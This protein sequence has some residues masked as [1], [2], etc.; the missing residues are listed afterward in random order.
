MADENKAFEAIVKKQILLTGC[1]FSKKENRISHLA[2]SLNY[3]VSLFK[4]TGKRH[5]WSRAFEIG[6]LLVNHLLSKDYKSNC[7]NIIEDLNSLIQLYLITEND[8]FLIHL[9]VIKKFNE[10]LIY[11]EISKNEADLKKFNLLLLKLSFFDLTGNRTLLYQINQDISN[12]LRSCF[13]YKRN[14]KSTYRLFYDEKDRYKA[15]VLFKRS[16]I[17]TGAYF[18][19]NSLL[20][21]ANIFFLEKTKC[22][23]KKYKLSAISLKSLL[24][25]EISVLESELKLEFL[26]NNKINP[27]Y[28]QKK[29][30]EYKLKYSNCIDLTFI[31]TY[32]SAVIFLKLSEYTNILSYKRKCVIY[33]KKIISLISQKSVYKKVFKYTNINNLL[34]KVISF[35]KIHNK[36]LSGQKKEISY[37]VRSYFPSIDVDDKNLKMSLLY[38]SFPKT[39]SILGNLKFNLYFYLSHDIRLKKTLLTFFDAIKDII[40]N[41]AFHVLKST[42][43][44]ELTKFKQLSKF[45][46]GD[47]YRNRENHFLSNSV[48]IENGDIFLFKKISIHPSL[49]Y[50]SVKQHSISKAIDFTFKGFICNLSEYEFIVKFNLKNIEFEEIIVN[51]VDKIIVKS[52]VNKHFLEDCVIKILNQIKYND[53]QYE[54]FK[55]IIINRIFILLKRGALVIWN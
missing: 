32:L 34:F 17:E 31:Y 50:L 35:N 11:R 46:L 55:K 48:L 23:K 15:S 30:K 51:A 44:S 1:Y 38:N 41:N 16:L 43:K 37:E 5:H 8:K 49:K 3:Y 21:L 28:I 22:I 24:E 20:E 12:F 2:D 9:K 47:E 10:G 25:C 7:K 14:I 4:I 26:M 40:E 39:I 27:L 29:K 36:S 13:F 53:N 52:L 54:S 33:T 42:F 45:E 6:D 18:Q 19:N